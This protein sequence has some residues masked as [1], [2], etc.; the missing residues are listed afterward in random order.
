MKTEQFHNETQ[1]KSIINLNILEKHIHVSFFLHL[2]VFLYIC[3][4]FSNLY[5][6]LNF[7]V[8]KKDAVAYVNIELYHWGF[9]FNLGKNQN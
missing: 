7:I 8:M 2:W 3:K 9:L 4:I 5:T 1:P 6:L